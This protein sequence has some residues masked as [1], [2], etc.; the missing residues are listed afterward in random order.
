MPKIS[1][2][3]YQDGDKLIHVKQHDYNPAL[4]QAEM[5]RQN[6]N[7]HFGESVCIGVVDAALM[8]EWLK[9]AGVK[10]NDPAAEEVIKR[11]MLSGEFDKLRVWDGKY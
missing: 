5:M 2:Q 9:E 11:K 6:G 7:A 4:E 1:E 8:H 3:F 10:S